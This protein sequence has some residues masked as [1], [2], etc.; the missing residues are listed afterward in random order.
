MAYELP[1]EVNFTN[2]VSIRDAGKRHIDAAGAATDIAADAVEFERHLVKVD[3]D[4]CTSCM[5]CIEDFG[6][7][8]LRR[9]D[10]EIV[11]DEVTC[12]GCGVCVDVCP[13]GAIR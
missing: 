12:V 3:Q 10:G 6:C 8:A 11:V 7:P 9:Q 13:A 1:A 2:R 5:V 4:A